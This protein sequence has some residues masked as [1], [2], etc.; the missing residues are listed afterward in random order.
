MAVEKG[1]K[2]EKGE[3]DKTLLEG[4]NGKVWFEGE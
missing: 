4:Q 2:G 1:E 3:T